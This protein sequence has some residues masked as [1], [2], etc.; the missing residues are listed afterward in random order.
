M[1][2]LVLVRTASKG[3]ARV[4]EP[5]KFIDWSNSSDR[6]WL[7]NHL[8]WAMMNDTAVML[9]PEQYESN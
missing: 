1:K 7:N 5:R 8:H 3:G 4:N 9:S 6:K 2:H